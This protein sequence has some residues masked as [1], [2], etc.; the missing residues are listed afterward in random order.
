MIAGFQG[1]MSPK[2]HI[3]CPRNPSKINDLAH[4]DGNWLVIWFPKGF[5]RGLGGS[6]RPISLKKGNIFLVTILKDTQET[7]NNLKDQTTPLACCLC[8]LK[9]YL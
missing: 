1:I 5:P 7:L 3:V 2:E 9:D 4:L 8:V 6:C